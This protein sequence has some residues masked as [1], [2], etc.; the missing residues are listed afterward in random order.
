MKKSQGQ[1]VI[2]TDTG[3][4]FTDCVVVTGSGRVLVGKSS[5]TPMDL[6]ECF[7]KSIDATLEAGEEKGG[8]EF[9]RNTRVVGYGTTQGTNLVITGTGAPNLGFITT[10]G[11]EDRTIIGRHRAA[12]LGPEE[13][14]HIVMADKPEPLIPRTR[15]KG[16]AERVDSFGEVLVALQDDEVR[17]VV[18]DLVEKEKVKGIAVGFL[19]SFLNPGHE[20][21]VRE[22][23]QELYPHL[24]VA[25]SY[26]VNPIVREEPR[27]RTTQI[28]LYIG[29]ALRELLGRVESSLHERGYRYPLLVLQAAGGVSRAA[30]VKPANTLHSGPVGGLMGVEF[31]KKLYG[32]DNGIGSDVGGT[33][34]DITV[35]SKTGLAYLRE[36]LV[37]RFQISNPML[38]IIT[39][40]AG[41]GT[42]AK[43]DP[44]TNDLRVGPESAGA[45]PAPVCYGRGGTEPTVTDADLVLNRID[46]E[47]FLGGRMKLD[48]DKAFKA[49]EEKIAKPLGK[50][51]Y[52][53]AAAVVNIVDATMGTTLRATLAARGLDPAQ[54]TLFGFGGAGPSHCAGYSQGTG[55]R[56]V[57]VPELA[58]VFSAFGAS[59]APIRHRHEG[60]PFVVISQLPYDKVS[61]RFKK[62]EITPASF[63]QWA[64]ERL[65]NMALDL[66]RAAKE[67]MYSEGFKDGEFEL[68]Y[69]MLARY[70]GQLWE[71]RAETPSIRVETTEDCAALLHAFEET[72]VKAYGSGAMVPAGGIEI[73]CVSV[74]AIAQ[75]EHPGLC[76]YEFTGQSPKRAEKGSR[77][78]YWKQGFLDTLVYEWDLLGNGNVIEGPAIVESTTT[79]FVIPPGRRVVVDQYRSMR[80]TG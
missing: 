48:R 2:Y 11:H 25:L 79:T 73:V 71:T 22:I 64:R 54:F 9:Y 42:I 7:F 24:P 21:R 33:S 1:N 30:I 29:N 77:S 55:F 36:P 27:F 50:D 31:L 23:I 3:G 45:S 40:G 34:F 16:V 14:M 52:Q 32:I 62:G 49:F 46:P 75:V 28:D 57:I 26:E 8:S 18:K 13:G 39:I 35:S 80:M 68:Q 56:E 19:W 43:I 44:S 37:G 65:N 74:D 76:A 15:I 10:K 51:V 78:V 58:A 6:E 61:L 70:G 41:G 12:G 59:T 47:Y 63:P 60:S 67:D 66:E 69:G 20:R 72:Y 53:A 5:T 38:E 4:T 17:K